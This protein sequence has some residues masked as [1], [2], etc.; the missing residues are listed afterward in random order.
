MT[1]ATLFEQ[2]VQAGIYLRGWSQ[3]TP[4]IY[5]RAFASFQKA[6]GIHVNLGTLLPSNSKPEGFQSV[7]RFLFGLL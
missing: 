1:L 7:R 4:I 6:Q 3:K 5:R 2:F